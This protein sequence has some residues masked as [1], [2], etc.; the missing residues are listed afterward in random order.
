MSL[1]YTPSDKPGR[2]SNTRLK[3]LQEAANAPLLTAA[4]L[5]SSMK[6]CENS[7][8]GRIMYSGVATYSTL[9]R[10]SSGRSSASTLQRGNGGIQVE[11]GHHH[12]STQ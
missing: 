10:L 9:P 6:K 2:S 12:G 1:P 5:A 7:M 3:Q 4:E 11:M 8:G